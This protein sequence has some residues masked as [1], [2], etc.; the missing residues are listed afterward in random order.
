MPNGKILSLTACVLV[1]AAAGADYG[2]GQVEI[3]RPHRL[4]VEGFPTTIGAWQGGA[5]QEVDPEI[6]SKL[7]T[8]KIV[9]RDYVNPAGEGVD[10][11]L[12]TATEDED[13]HSP[14]GCFPSQG[15]KLTGIHSVLAD[16]VSAT[17]MSAAF[18]DGQRQQVRY[19]LTG[20][21]PPAP[22]RSVFLQKLVAARDHVVGPHNNL[23][24]FVRII[25]PDTPQGHQA[26]EDFTTALHG[27]LQTLIGPGGAVAA[28]GK[29][30][31]RF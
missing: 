14:Q 28:P 4:P 17:E 18:P 13:M 22:P 8:A 31:R 1:L 19:W 10:L 6:Q 3:A 15:W 11:M 26:L 2:L 25:A 29:L 24:L 5:L 7:A 21:F 12:L 16:G 27:P 30:P 20:Y 9:E 23:S